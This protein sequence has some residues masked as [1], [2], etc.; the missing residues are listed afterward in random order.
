MSFPQA[1]PYKVLVID[2][3]PHLNETMVISLEMFGH[4]EVISAFDGMA[5]LELCLTNPPDIVVIDV[6]M[7]E[8]DG[9]QVVRALRGD[10]ETADLPLIILS[11]MV[12]ENDQLTGI[13][14]G[15]DVYLKKPLNPYQLV[16][17]ISDVLALDPHR[18][19]ERMRAIGDASIDS[20]LKERG[21]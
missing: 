17:A 6:K 7:P 8:L 18:R 10:P 4:F 14:S 15:V 13:F 20:I 19:L 9:Y 16:Q 21:E 2:D 12:Q 1:R 5:G 3:D 11:A